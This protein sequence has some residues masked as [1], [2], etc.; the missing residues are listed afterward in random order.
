[1]VVSHRQ[2][3]SC[4][5]RSEHF[6]GVI[7]VA[8]VARTKVVDFMAASFQDF[9]PDPSAVASGDEIVGRARHDLSRR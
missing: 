5:S 2:L 3:H 8:S 4:P 9:T 7:A 6:S 1:M